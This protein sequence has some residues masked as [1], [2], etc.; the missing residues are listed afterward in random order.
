MRTLLVLV[1]A[2]V[3]HVAHADDGDPPGQVTGRLNVG[4][5]ILAG[6]GIVSRTARGNLGFDVALVPERAVAVTLGLGLT[7]AGGGFS[8]DLM[9]DE[10]KHFGTSDFGL[11]GELGL[12]WNT[13]GAVHNRI[14]ATFSVM[15]VATDERWLGDHGELGMRAS[16]GANWAH[17]IDKGM[18]ETDAIQDSNDRT[19]IWMLYPLL[20]Q[21]LELTWMKSLD[22]DRFGVTF[23]WGI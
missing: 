6:D 8:S 3:P 13:D 18:D 14:Y 19:D 16:V 12:R 20:P 15:R 7:A 5:E 4:A 1:L 11:R 17:S 2:T 21:Q 10:G 22:T 9:R 23:S